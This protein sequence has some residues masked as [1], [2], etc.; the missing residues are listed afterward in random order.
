MK[1]LSPY[2]SGIAGKVEDKGTHC[3]C[4]RSCAFGMLLCLSEQFL[5]TMAS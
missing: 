1:I 5:S 3:N 4:T 2:H